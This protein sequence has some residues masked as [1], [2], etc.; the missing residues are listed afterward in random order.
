MDDLAKRVG[1]MIDD[2]CAAK[3]RVSRL[4]ADKEILRGA[5]RRARLPA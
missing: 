4:E 5:S 2:L 3:A 1:E